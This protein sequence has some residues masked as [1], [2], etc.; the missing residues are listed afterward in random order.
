MSAP[1]DRRATAI[2]VV[3]ASIA[4]LWAAPGAFAE[5][6]EHPEIESGTVRSTLRRMEE[7]RPPFVSDGHAIFSF[8][9]EGPTRYV[10]AAFKHEDFAKRRLFSVNDHGIYV[11]AYEYPAELDQLAYRLEVDGLWTSDPLAPASRR[12]E[13]GWELSILELPEPDPDRHAM[14]RTLDDGRTL[15]EFTYEPGKRVHLSGT[16]NNWN[17]YRHRMTEVEQGRYRIVLRLPPG[18]HFYHF[19]VDGRRYADPRNEEPRYVRDGMPA[20]RA[21]IERSARALS[22]DRA[23]S[24]RR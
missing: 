12:S 1:G 18:E 9:P 8:E 19:V 2:C 6:V 16:F 5:V 13:S 20:S 10:T 11:L 23:P 4:L 3:L 22:S 24:P 7:P 17:P 14:P 21:T 15:F